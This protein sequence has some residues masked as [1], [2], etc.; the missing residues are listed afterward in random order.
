MEI[1]GTKTFKPTFDYSPLELQALK[2]CEEAWE[3]YQAVKHLF[4]VNAV[5]D[6]D[7]RMRDLRGEMADV[8]QTL[9][10]LAVMVGLD[11]R[12]VIED[13]NDCHRR[14]VHRGRV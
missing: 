6:E 9:F 4:D 8:H 12:D 11:E 14:N 13:M 7:A 3:V 2:V 5:I 1:L 10:N